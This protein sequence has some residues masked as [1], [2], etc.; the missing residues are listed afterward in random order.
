MSTQARRKSTE[1]TDSETSPLEQ[2]A[3]TELTNSETSPIINS[4]TQNNEQLN[5]NFIENIENT[6]NDI[7]QQY[8]FIV[9][10][11]DPI[12]TKKDTLTIEEANKIIGTFASTANSDINTAFAAITALCQSGG[13]NKSTANIK[14]TINGITFELDTL[15]NTIKLITKDGTVRKLAKT[16]RDSIVAIASINDWPGPLA[17]VISK[18]NP[19]TQ[20]TTGDLIWAAEYHDDNPKAPENIRKALAARSQANRIASQERTKTINKKKSNKKN[21]K[22]GRKN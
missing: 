21:N 22:S 1:Q 12:S 14:K 17:K 10:T 19:E 18:E 4:N 16:I 15:R 5:T 3:T 2:I 6:I 7:S 8:K 13:T 9:N 20:Y 11:T